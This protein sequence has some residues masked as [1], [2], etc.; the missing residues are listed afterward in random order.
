M[1]KFGPEQDPVPAVCP[2]SAAV[3]ELEGGER[4]S[5]NDAGRGEN[6]KKGVAEVA[7]QKALGEGGAGDG[8][9]SRTLA[10]GTR[11]S[12]RGGSERMTRR[13]VGWGRHCRVP[14]LLSTVNFF[15]TA[16]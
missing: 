14:N 8:R 4:G 10:V 5:V 15:T 2:N 13:K 7:V 9:P 1:R 3:G 16:C 11:T 12:S 6:L